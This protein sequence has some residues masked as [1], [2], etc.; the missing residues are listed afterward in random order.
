MSHVEYYSKY[1]ER[2]RYK[3]GILTLLE[4]RKY[5]KTKHLLFKKIPFYKLIKS[6]T[7]KYSGLDFKW[8]SNSIFLLQEAFENFLTSFLVDCNICA[9]HGKRVTISNFLS[10]LVNKDIYL[11][12]RIRG[13]KFLTN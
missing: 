11:A 2:K 3:A 10:F 1:P 7:N 13:M 9:V 5:Q 12:K 4:I 8:S 6:I